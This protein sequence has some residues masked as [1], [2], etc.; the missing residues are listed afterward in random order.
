MKKFEGFEAVLLLLWITVAAASA[1]VT[2]EVEFPKKYREV[3]KLR[4]LAIEFVDYLQNFTTEDFQKD[5]SSLRLIEENS[6]CFF[7]FALL[8]KGLVSSEQWAGQMIDSCGSLPSGVLYGNY[9]DLGNYDECVNIN[10]EI[11]SSGSVTGKYCFAA[12]PK[13]LLG[14]NADVSIAICFP[15]S[16]AAAIMDTLLRGLLHQLLGQKLSNDFKVVNE[17]T[18]RIAKRDPIYG[19][20]IFTIVILFIMALLVLLATLYD[21]VLDSMQL[22][23]LIEVF[24][25][26]ASSRSLFRFEDGKLNPNVIDCIH[27]MRCMS[28]I[29]VAPLHIQQWP[30]KIQMIYCRCF[31][32]GACSVSQYCFR[33]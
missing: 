13:L 8:I 15:S 12:V 30:F 20:T 7:D 22:P 1:S 16:C 4:Q 25:A 3:T 14:L 32:S 6:K 24:S 9:R 26:R 2:K 31:V 29:W 28:L 11:T 10:Q 23:T 21:Y 27:G 5:D 17:Y 18:C 33:T 19:L